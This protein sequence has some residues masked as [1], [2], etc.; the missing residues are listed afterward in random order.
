MVVDIPNHELQHPLRGIDP[1]GNPALQPDITELNIYGD[2]LEAWVLSKAFLSRVSIPARMNFADCCT[3]AS[4]VYLAV[5]YEAG[6]IQ[7]AEVNQNKV[8]P[9]PTPFSSTYAHC[10]KKNLSGGTI[11]AIA[12]GAFLG[13]VVIILTGYCIYKKR[14]KTTTD[15]APKTTASPSA[16]DIEI[17]PHAERVTSYTSDLTY[18]PAAQDGGPL[19]RWEISG[20]RRTFELPSPNGGY[21]PPSPRAPDRRLQRRPVGS[22][23]ENGSGSTWGQLRANAPWHV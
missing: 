3:D 1:S 15:P 9:D 20:E 11:A 12:L 5:D 19:Q 14:R 10:K 17:L 21:P 7:L 8:T 4:Q 13:L 23:G 18:A 6:S 22:G 16:E 2:P